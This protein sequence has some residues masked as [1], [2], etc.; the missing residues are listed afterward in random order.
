M[1]EKF[2]CP[3]CGKRSLGVGCAF[4]GYPNNYESKEVNYGEAIIEII[5]SIEAKTNLVIYLEHEKETG[6]IWIRYEVKGGYITSVMKCKTPEEL[7]YKLTG[8]S[9]CIN[10]FIGGAF[11]IAETIKTKK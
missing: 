3:R 2:V 7:Y 4:C 9:A 11:K 10:D 8:Y 5:K 1:G 6:G